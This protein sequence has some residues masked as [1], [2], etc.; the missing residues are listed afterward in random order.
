MVGA[1]IG[2]GGMASVYLGRRAEDDPGQNLVALK[3]IKDTLA[4]DKQYEVMFDDEAK[5]LS[6]LDHPSIIRHV[7]YGREGEWGYI[8][9]E[10]VL[11]RSLMDAWDACNKAGRH[12]PIDLSAHVGLCVAE[13]LAYAHT[14][15]DEQGKPLD[16]IHRDVNPTNIFLTYD[17]QVK[18]IDFGLAKAKGRAYKSAEGIVKGKVPYLAPEQ[19]TEE[20][21]DHRA[22]IYALGA[23]IW[24]MTTGRRLFKRDTDGET[25]RAIK[26]HVIPDP[27][28]I[29]EGWYPEALW[30]IVLH[31][32]AKD[33]AERYSTAKELADDLRG[34]LAKYGRKAPMQAAMAE[35]LE[36]LF[37]NEHARQAEWL[38]EAAEKALP[39]MT[40]APPAPIA[41][42]PDVASRTKM[43]VAVDHD[44]SS[45]LPPVIEDK[46]ANEEKKVNASSGVVAPKPRSSPP[47][48]RPTSFARA[49][50]AGAVV[51]AVVVAAYMALRG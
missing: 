43:E 24:E 44:T 50:L 4:G 41:E 17:G 10:L 23:T 29:V 12:M 26:A 31:A 11:G 13:A 16:V 32:L 34:M 14:L 2:G 35:F 37:P 40:M 20:Q 18:L 27:R 30:K 1:K 3:V 45:P 25:I 51:G 9:M 46:P 15:T 5:I 47:A 21:I 28:T 42:I 48:Q 6:R 19:I 39:R 8:A 38:I 33:R 36:E 7:D 22:D 49:L